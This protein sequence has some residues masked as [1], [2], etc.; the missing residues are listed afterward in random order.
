MKKE[1]AGK[2]DLVYMYVCMGHWRQ[3]YSGDDLHELNKQNIIKGERNF[4]STTQ[5]RSQTFTFGT[6]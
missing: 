1:L 5:D 4:L 3:S 2:V 6:A